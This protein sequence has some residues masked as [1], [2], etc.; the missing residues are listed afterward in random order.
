MNEIAEITIF[1]HLFLPPS[2]LPPSNL[3][4][5]IVLFQRLLLKVSCRCIHSKGLSKSAN[6]F[7]RRVVRPAGSYRFPVQ[8]LPY[9]ALLGE[10]MLLQT[11]P[12]LR[13]CLSPAGAGQRG[14]G[15]R[16]RPRVARGSPSGGCPRRRRRARPP[17]M[18]RAMPEPPARSRRCSAR[19]AL[20]RRSA[21]GCGGPGSIPVPTPTEPN[22]DNHRWIGLPGLAFPPSG[23]DAV[24]SARAGGNPPAAAGHGGPGAGAPR[25]APSARSIPPAGAGAPRTSNTS[26]GCG[27]AAKTRSPSVCSSPFLCLFLFTCL[28]LKIRHFSKPLLRVSSLKALAGPGV[29]RCGTTCRQPV[30]RCPPKRWSCLRARL[31]TAWVGFSFGPSEALELRLKQRSFWKRD[32][33]NSPPLERFFCWEN[34]SDC[35]ILFI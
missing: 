9:S 25:T 21:T 27:S 12:L 14:W 2:R 15:L 11:C 33:S 23:A 28:L 5:Q 22:P 30:L 13:A 10:I 31:A 6:S 29:F 35:K 8:S 26:Y 34:N 19:G 18:L 17:G 24:S 32:H 3:V 4:P 1:T 20:K 16:P 7:P